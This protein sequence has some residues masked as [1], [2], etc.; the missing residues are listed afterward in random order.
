MATPRSIRPARPLTAV[1]LALAV[2]LPLVGCTPLLEAFNGAP[3]GGTES[4]SQVSVPSADPETAF[5][6]LFTDDGS[7]SLTSDVAEDLEVRLDVWA[8]DPKRTREWMPMGEKT[9]GFAVN[10]YDH[11]VDDKAVLT[12]KRRVYISQ[13]AIT[14]QTA[15][16]GGQVSTPF[17]FAA[18]PRTLVPSDTL[19]SER[20]LLLNSYQGGLHVPETTINQLP[21]DTFGVTLQFQ[22]SVWVE[23]SADDD[24]SFAQQTVYHQLPITIFPQAETDAD[25]ETS[26][27]SG[28]GGSSEGP[29]P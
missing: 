12:Q 14:S 11:R 21:P 15:Q 23:G 7:V 4:V 17:Q 26:T 25:A 16:S 24:T 8:A 2:T 27:G 9:F 18:D 28:A 1:A 10:V 20:G 19:R 3:S 5:E 29:T 22:L 6:S 13:I